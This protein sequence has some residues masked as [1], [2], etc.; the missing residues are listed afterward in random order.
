MT[1]GISETAEVLQFPGNGQAVDIECA[2]AEGNLI[3]QRRASRYFIGTVNAF[4][5]DI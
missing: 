5:K 4:F 2:R 3:A 1:I